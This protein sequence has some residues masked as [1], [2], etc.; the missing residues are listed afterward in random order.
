VN[1]E[2]KQQFVNACNSVDGIDFI[3]E[4]LGYLKDVATKEELN[5]FVNIFGGVFKIKNIESSDALSHLCILL[6]DKIYDIL[7]A[8]GDV[9]ESNYIHLYNYFSY[10]SLPE[11]TRYTAYEQFV[12]QNL[13]NDGISD[14]EKVFLI[15][16]RFFASFANSRSDAFVKFFADTTRLNI[17]EAGSIGFSGIIIDFLEASLVTTEEILAVMDGLLEKERYFALSK[18][19]R[20]SLFNWSLHCL[21]LIQKYFN[22]PAWTS[23]YPTWKTI[24]Y[25]HIARDECDEAMYVHFF[26]YHKMGNSFQTQAEWK[27]FNDEIDRPAADYYKAWC[28]RAK[29]PKCKES[30]SEGRKIIGILQ[31]RFVENSPFKVLYSV[32]KDVMASR[33][34]REQ[35]DVRIYLMSYFEKSENDLKCINMVEKLGI[36]VWD[37]ATPFYGDGIYHSHLGKALYIRQKIIDDGVDIMIHGASYDIND[38]LVVSRVVPKQIYWIHGNFEFDVP[39]IDKR[40]T[41]ISD[42]SHMKQSDYIVEH[43]DFQTNE[44]YLNPEEEGKRKKAEIIRSR[45]SSNTVVFGS[46]GRL[47]KI[48]N[49]DFLRAVLQILQRC[50]EAVYLACGGGNVESI[51]EKA[52]E[53]GMPM[54]RFLF[55]GY[56]DP[57]VYGYA[58]DIYLN[59]FPE[60]SGQAAIE[61]LE[62]TKYKLY[63]GYDYG[64]LMPGVCRI[65]NYVLDALE[66]CQAIKNMGKSSY[67]S[68]FKVVG[69]NSVFRPDSKNLKKL[70]DD[71]KKIR[72]GVGRDKVILG[73]VCVFDRAANF[74]FLDAIRKILE[75]DRNT[76]YILCG[77]GDDEFI[78]NYIKQHKLIDRFYI[79][80]NKDFHACSMAIDVALNTFPYV[81]GPLFDLCSQDKNV[82]TAEVK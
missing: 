60:P 82:V 56:V 7:I 29:L 67:L 14:I 21:W 13:Y 34:F 57:H 58:I 74:D 9:P 65:E 68:R 18:I 43:F 79:I 76:V 50:P 24:F 23:L 48:D 78:I 49:Y 22:H 44:L 28:E 63:V 51:K 17:I 66:C 3:A 31:D 11:D 55:E 54:E 75:N 64:D 38:F 2:S 19:D 27:T 15:V 4:S 47:V 10:C 71:A 16:L 30:Q 36:T 61:F 70:E 80:K 39:N 45:F 33:E 41:H 59:T 69:K 40:I 12:D 62:K 42:E 52:I 5:D 8:N 73:S 77:F 25:E 32:L 53:L 37:G 1:M 72:D 35:Y 6:R 26:I 81:F 20:R 46:I